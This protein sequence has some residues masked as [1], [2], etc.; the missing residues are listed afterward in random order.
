MKSLEI[1][2]ILVKYNRQQP[3]YKNDNKQASANNRECLTVLNCHPY[4]TI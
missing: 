3:A 2:V 1:P 4:Q